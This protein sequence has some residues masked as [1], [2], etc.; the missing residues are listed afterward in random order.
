MTRDVKNDSLLWLGT[1][2]VLFSFNT[3]TEKHH[4]YRQIHEDHDSTNYLN[5]YR[6]VVQLDDRKI[7]Y[8]T[9]TTT[10]QVFNPETES[11]SSVDLNYPEEFNIDRFT[12]A[13][14]RKENGTQLW[15]RT[16]LGLFLFD[17]EKKEIINSKL[18]DLVLEQIYGISFVDRDNRIWFASK[19]GAHIFDPLMQQFN[20]YDFKHLNK[21]NLNGLVR[22]IIP[23]Y[24]KNVLT[25]IVQGG[26]GLFHFDRD[27]GKWW[28][29]DL[30]KYALDE[31]F[32]FNGFD[33]APH[34][35]LDW[36]ITSSTAIFLFNP[37]TYKCRPFPVELEMKSSRFHNVTW[38]KK[39]RLW[40]TTL[41]DGLFRWDPKTNQ[42]VQY[43]D[44]FKTKGS[45]EPAV[46]SYGFVDSRNNVWIKRREG[47]CVYLDAQ[48]SIY[49]SLFSD[50][51]NSSINAIRG[52][53]EDRYGRVWILGAEGDLGFINVNNPTNKLDS[54]FNLFETGLDKSFINKIS[55]DKEGNVWVLADHYLAKIDSTLNISTFSFE[56][57]EFPEEFFEFDFTSSNEL[58]LGMRNNI[59]IINPNNLRRNENPPIP[60]L[61]EVRIKEKPIAGNLFLQQSGLKLKHNE[62]FISFEFSSINFTLPHNTQYWYRLKGLDP[63]WIE[64]GKRRYVNYTSVPSGDYVFEVKAA[65][66]EGIKSDSAAG[67]AIS[68]ATPWW[69]TWIFRILFL[70]SIAGLFYLIYRFRINQIRKQ[71]KVK[72]SFEKKLANVELSALRAQMNPHFIFNCLNSIEFYILKNETLKAAQYINDFAR[73]IRLI[74]QNSR[75]RYVP[76]HDEFE[77]LD[78]YLQME[79]LRF[80]DKFAYTIHVDEELK[81]ENIDIP[82][83]LIQPYVEN[84]LWHGIMHK[85][86]GGIVNISIKRLNGQLHCVIDDN[87]I[88]RKK[89]MEINSKRKLKRR[90]S[91]GMDITN[92]RMHI[93][94]EIYQTNT[95][96]EVIDKVDKNGD[97]SGTRVELFI[98]A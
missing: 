67:I 5:T 40:I 65:N 20:F 47:H 95:R 98:S 6:K 41:N 39:D 1:T 75:S 96:V 83:M 91:M 84:S 18:N 86:E 78:L 12:I 4:F 50:K 8:N 28:R 48:D 57:G 31:D 81:E 69:E 72:T 9:W 36:V 52:F 74:L 46:A 51:S 56:Y 33:V 97:A 38:D 92:D 34:P 60:Y 49:V 26:N 37:K 27:Q 30:P 19:T 21:K 94:N 13:D 63:E 22:R 44:D 61:S 77:A 82:P 89:S 80:G 90:K 7:Y 32:I 76:L 2:S 11:Y 79:S 88:G 64:A 17:T 70:G 14:I 23:H 10:P 42:V 87:G 68:I 45:V 71:E 24:D 53:A 58:M 55:S 62:N 29:T 73:L 59:A 16:Q 3:H 66:N 43:I 25:A 93:I 85:S 15:Y 54:T 35:T